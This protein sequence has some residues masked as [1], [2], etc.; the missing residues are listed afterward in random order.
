MNAR[1]RTAAFWLAALVIFVGFLLVFRSILLPF[2][3]GM[4]IA[5]ALDPIA[6]RLERLGLGRLAAAVVILLAFLVVLLVVVLALG[7]VLI[8][9]LVD[10]ADN[11]PSYVERLQDLLGL[12]INSKVAAFLGLD[13]DNIRDS[14]RSLLGGGTELMAT[15]V[16]SIWS[17]GQALVSIGSLLVVTPFVVFYLLRDWPRMIDW[18]DGLLPRDHAD[19][20]RGLAAAIDAKV[21]A[22]VRGQLLVALLLGI[23]Y[24][25]GLMVVG[26]NFGLLIGLASGL[27]SLIPYLGFTVGF[28]ISIIVAVVQFWPDWILPAATVAVFLAGQFLEGFVLQP[29]LLG[30]RVGLHPVW[31][32]F[33]LFAF[34][35]LFG[36]V[37]LLIAVPTAA[38]V[39]VLFGHAIERYRAGAVF[40]GGESDDAG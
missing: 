37:G 26:V 19:E 5:Y 7:P 1:A 36:F 4:A 13:A 38:A 27:L 32:F 34:A 24:A 14:V 6:D 23:F 31:L 11:L 30:R 17:G 15:F 18:I 16:Q 10:L 28:V 25:A 39:G 35:L 12:A 22:F 2:V 21:A 29:R 3:A 33:S 40:R 8:G 20:I 9:Q